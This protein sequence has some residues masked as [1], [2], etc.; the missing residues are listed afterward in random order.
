MQSHTGQIMS[1][2]S[3]AMYSSSKQKIK[4]QSSTEAEPVGVNDAM[5]Q[6]LWTKY[7]IE[8]QGYNV[9][10]NIIYQDNQICILLEK[11][12]QG[13]NRKRTCHSNIHYFF[14]T[15]KIRQG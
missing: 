1:L 5:S 10:H 3:G 14:V 9:R 2:G 15:D 12:G 6:I 13:S 4:T 7:F 11:N 8:A